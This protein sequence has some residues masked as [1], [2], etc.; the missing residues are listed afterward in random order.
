M[1]PPKKNPPIHHRRPGDWWKPEVSAGPPGMTFQTGTRMIP[2]E[3]YA[4][5]AVQRCTRDT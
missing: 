5:P 4:E 1:E 3:S 2:V